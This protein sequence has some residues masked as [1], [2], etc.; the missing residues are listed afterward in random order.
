MAFFCFSEEV[1]AEE[2]RQDWAAAD[3]LDWGSEEFAEWNPQGTDG[4]GQY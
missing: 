4:K 1:K 2:P 3:R